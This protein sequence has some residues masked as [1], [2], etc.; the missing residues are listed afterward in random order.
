MQTVDGGDEAPGGR[1]PA[2]SRGVLAGSLLPTMTAVGA[3]AVVVLALVG[4][5]S[6]VLL[7]VAVLGAASAVGMVSWR[8][9]NREK[10]RA[11]Q[12]EL[13]LLR[14]QEQRFRML[15]QNS[16]D[17]VTVN[18]LE[19]TIRYMS[20]GSQRMFGRKPGGRRGGNIL[21][22]VHPDDKGR[23]ARVLREVATTPGSSQLYQMRF[24]HSDGSWRW[25]EVLSSNL[26][27]EPS[28]RGIVSNTRDI[29]E[30]RELQDRLSHEAH[31]DALTGL[32]NRV[33]LYERLRQQL[34]AG[35]TVV[36]VDLDDF[37]VV[38]DSLGHAVGDELL[39]TVADRMRR[40]VRPE[41]TVARL[42]GD[43]FALLLTADETVPTEL[44][45]S[46]I[47]EALGESVTVGGHVLA[48]KASF[49]IAESRP[50]DR[51]GDLMRRA[52][53]AMYRAKEDGEGRWRYYE[54]GMTVRGGE[55]CELA[56]E[57][58][59]ALD[60]GEL[61]LFYQP[62]V[63]LPSGELTG[64]EALVRWDHPE[65]GMLVPGDFLPVAEASGLIIPLGSWVLHEACGQAGRWHR[66]YGDHA[67]TSISINMSAR[68]LLLPDCADDVERA[69]RDSGL[70]AHRLIVE[71]TESTALGGG[72][73]VTNLRRIRELGVRLSLDDFGTGQSTL[74][75]LA[76]TPVDQIKL[77]RSFVPAPGADVMAIAVV[78]LAQLLGLEAVA[79]GV[80]TPA[81]A[82]RLHA[83]GYEHAQGFHFARPM[84]ADDLTAA[85]HT[86]ALL[87]DPV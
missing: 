65:R 42:G 72:A 79:E 64:V 6:G 66:E 2:L 46:R 58:R 52:D 7:A 19:G 14:E 74:S 59:R 87:A 35:V 48:V 38:N 28:V 30:M 12:G 33:L 50:G 36:L 55:T 4:A 44:V 85:L 82:D 3:V 81:Q 75:L 22:L 25:V 68:Q 80:E 70:P 26:L 51:A 11:V 21:E 10:W 86:P 9:A 78:Q 8:W 71:I 47:I 41:D 54:S 57:L 20:G 77:D 83:L 73:T 23:V 60:D 40:T 49:G 15:V 62:M 32:A 31:H 43:E 56:D 18:D 16:Y 84:S 24:R 37:K 67:P 45:L 27:D 53:I 13:A 76:S 39:V 61:R 29:T 69:L 63:T 5:P 17:V 1:L 34:D